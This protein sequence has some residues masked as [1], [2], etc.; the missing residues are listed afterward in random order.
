MGNHRA[1]RTPSRHR[2]IVL[3]GLSVLGLA[4]TAALGV[5]VAPSVPTN[6]FQPTWP[7]PEK[8]RTVAAAP[9]TNP[10]AANAQEDWVTEIQVQLAAEQKARDDEAA[11]IAAEQAEAERVAAEQAE[12]QAQAEAEAE[13]TAEIAQ[14][15][16]EAEVE[17]VTPESDPEPVEDAPEA[18]SAPS[19]DYQSYALDLLGGDADELAALEVL[20]GR[21]SGWNPN[22]QNPSSTAYGIPQFLN[23]TWAGTGI[24]KTSD[25]YLQIEA[26]LIYIE[27]RYGSPSAALT[28]SNATGWY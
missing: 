10:F 13:E 23:S 14:E 19:G 28:H 2:A 21:E 15:A 6:L 16:A 11:R 20:W 22:A 1:A 8:P 3:G 18:A 17:P 9:A 26:G 5:L 24:A 12:I 25:P 4:A 27:A 7:E